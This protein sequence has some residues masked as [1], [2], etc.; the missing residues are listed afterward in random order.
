MRNIYLYIGSFGALGALARYF[1]GSWLDLPHS[2]DFPAGTLACNLSGCFLLS[3]MFFAWASG[4]RLAREW[5][6]GL[7]TGLIG[8]FTTFSTFS[9]EA[10]ALV[11]AGA[12][13]HAFLYVAATLIGGIIMSFAGMIL[14]EKALGGTRR[15]KK[16][17]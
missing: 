12:W 4:S 10:M 1:L 5:Q 16:G 8:S 15:L 2:G 11:R 3:V 13:L 17:G 6:T 14:A 7:G 9:A